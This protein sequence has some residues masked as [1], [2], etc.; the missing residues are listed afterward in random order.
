MEQSGVTLVRIRGSV[1]LRATVIGGL[2][3]LGVYV[4]SEL[5]PVNN[6]NTFAGFI[7]GNCLWHKV[8]MVPTDTSRYVEVDIKSKRRLIDDQIVFAISAVAQAVTY[9]YAFKTLIRGG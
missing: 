9:N 6:P 8:V 3:F 1:N 5:S 7:D 4:V 2:A